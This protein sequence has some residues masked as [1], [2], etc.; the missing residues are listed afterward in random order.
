MD[1]I[2]PPPLPLQGELDKA[3]QRIGELTLREGLL[4]AKM[5]KPGPLSRQTREPVS[6]GN[7]NWLTMNRTKIDAKIDPSVSVAVTSPNKHR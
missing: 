7:L 2:L 5:G 3:M 6:F 1:G 4:D